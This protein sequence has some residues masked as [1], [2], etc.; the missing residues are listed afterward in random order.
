MNANNIMSV[1]ARRRHVEPVARNK[2]AVGS[3]SPTALQML[4]QI[5]A[6]LER[7]VDALATRPRQ[8][9][10][11]VPMRTKAEALEE[12][13]PED[14]TTALAETPKPRVNR[15]RLLRFFD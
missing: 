5:L 10:M 13:E 8:E 2:L 11:V 1:V 4:M 7:K 6:D 3:A 15:S 9:V 14:V 12:E